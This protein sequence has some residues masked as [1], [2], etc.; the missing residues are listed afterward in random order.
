MR[1]WQES[2]E[3][4]PRPGQMSPLGATFDGADTNFAVFSLDP[5]WAVEVDTAIPHTEFRPL[6][7]CGSEVEVEDRSLF[8]L[9]GHRQD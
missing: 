3:M 4:G 8:V 9:R 1:I 5:W 7:K 6:I 2:V